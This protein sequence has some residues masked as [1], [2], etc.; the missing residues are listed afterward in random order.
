MG[1]GIDKD[2]F[3]ERTKE[4]KRY[5]RELHLSVNNSLPSDREI[6]KLANLFFERDKD[7]RKDWDVE[8]SHV[9]R[10]FEWGMEAMRQII[11]GNDL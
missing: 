8:M 7:V 5:M 6:K 2:R 9:I 10:G 3:E 4:I 11:E 1:L